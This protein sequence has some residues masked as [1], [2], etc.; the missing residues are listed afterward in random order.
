MRLL[1]R[2]LA[3]RAESIPKL[4]EFAFRQVGSPGV[5]RG[6]T[7][8]DTQVDERP[9]HPPDVAFHRGN[10]E[11]LGEAIHGGR[12]QEKLLGATLE[13]GACVM[14][15]LSLRQTS[16][17]Y[18]VPALHRP[19]DVLGVNLI[20][21]DILM[22]THWYVPSGGLPLP[23]VGAARKSTSVGVVLENTVTGLVHSGLVDSITE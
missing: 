6:L 1:R 18:C 17:V 5:M 4:N 7:G 2:E 20:R 22:M 14:P 9:Q 8:E 16:A 15:P 21:S 3:Q 11:Y 10:K 12:K 13:S 19:S 23:S